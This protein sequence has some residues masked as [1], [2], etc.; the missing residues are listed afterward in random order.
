MIHYIDN[1]ITVN[2][3]DTVNIPRSAFHQ[4]EL[5]KQEELT[6]SEKEIVKAAF[7]RYCEN[8]VNDSWYIFE[9]DATNKCTAYKLDNCTAKDDDNYILFYNDNHYEASVHL[10]DDIIYVRRR[11]CNIETYTFKVKVPIILL[12]VDTNIEF[13]AIPTKLAKVAFSDNYQEVLTKCSVKPVKFNLTNFK[14]YLAN[15]GL[16]YTNNDLINLHSCTDS[17]YLTILAGYSGT[18]KSALAKAYVKYMTGDDSSR[19]KIIPIT[20]LFTEPSI[21][22]GFYSSTRN[23]YKPDKNGFINLVHEANEEDNQHKTYYVIFDEMNLA[24]VENWF[25]EFISKMESDDYLVLYDDTEEIKSAIDDLINSEEGGI[26]PQIVKKL[27]AMSKQFCQKYKSRYSL[28]NI[29]FIGTINEDESGNTVS[30]RVLDRA[31][32]VAL[33]RPNLV[34]IIKV[35]TKGIELGKY[36]SWFI[37]IAKKL[38]EA[39]LETISELEIRN[40]DYSDIE[41]FLISPR[42]I[43]T[44]LKYINSVEKIDG[45]TEFLENGIDLLL[46]QKVFSKLSANDNNVLVEKWSNVCNSDLCKLDKSLAK[47][48]EILRTLD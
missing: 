12:K 39:T 19:Y 29:K 2:G 6:N 8:R 46:C 28:R 33:Q 14:N 22:Y 27:E 34:E 13:L 18:G 45:G 7:R 43:I 38:N 26:P 5:I 35:A 23:V 24:P 42:V 40:K 37:E 11:R 44:S 31:N 47:L 48:N 10:E 4:L 1:N 9:C 25:C 30:G 20:P 32:K 21:L 17:N 16:W 15:E 41:K 3:C 36:Q